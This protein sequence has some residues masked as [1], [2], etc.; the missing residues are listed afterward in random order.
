MSDAFMF[1]R[2][3]AFPC[4]MHNSMDCVLSQRA[5]TSDLLEVPQEGA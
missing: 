1:G 2:H 3:Q 5:I 4:L